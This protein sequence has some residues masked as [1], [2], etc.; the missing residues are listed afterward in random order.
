[1]LRIIYVG[2]CT[3]SARTCVP[4]S[5]APAAGNTDAR[6]ATSSGV[7]VNVKAAD[8]WMEIVEREP[9]VGFRV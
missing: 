6:T 9:G 2:A 3:E 8:G 1:M 4:P 5:A 7:Y